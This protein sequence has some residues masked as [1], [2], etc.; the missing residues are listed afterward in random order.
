MYNAIYIINIIIFVSPRF[1]INI[2]ATN[3]IIIWELNL[4]LHSNL[5]NFCLKLSLVSSA[6]STGSDTEFIFRGRSFTNNRK[7]TGSE[8]YSCRTTCLNVHHSEKTLCCI[9]L[10]YFNVLLV[11]HKLNQSSDTPRIPW[12]SDFANKLSWFMQ[13]SLVVR[14]KFLQT[15]MLW[16]IYLNTLPPSRQ[17]FHY[18]SFFWQT[19]LFFD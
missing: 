6:N 7:N 11:K 13:S 4:S 10:F 1:T 8:I 3:H 14:T 17:H 19:V 12:K 2:L 18:A 5:R 15:C 16:L 9:R